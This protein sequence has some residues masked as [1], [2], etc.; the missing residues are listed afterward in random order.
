MPLYDY[1]CD[2]CT[3]EWEESHPMAACSETHPCPMCRSVSTRRIPRTTAIRPPP[4]SGWEYEN[5]GRGRRISQL[6]KDPHDMDCC[7]RTQSEA[8]DAA[9]ARGYLVEKP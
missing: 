6:A 9:K 8:A 4:D 1:G 2:R 5:G 7:Y 3:A